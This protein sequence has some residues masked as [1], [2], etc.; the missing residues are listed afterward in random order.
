MENSQAIKFLLDRGA[1]VFVTLT[2]NN[3][4]VSLLVQGGLETPCRVEIFMSSN[5]KKNEL[6]VI[7]RKYVDVLYYEREDSNT[8]GSFVEKEEDVSE[9]QSTHK[10]KKS[11]KIKQSG[12]KSGS[13]RST[14]KAS[15]KGIHSFFY[16][17]TKNA[18]QKTDFKE[19]KKER[20]KYFN[21]LELSKVTH[22]KTINV[23]ENY[24]ACF[25]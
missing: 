17:K 19:R 6:I 12:Q 13:I 21:S 11:P 4:C 8:V 24:K 18:H 20:K 23:L 14:S 25:I 16:V 9:R 3:Y 1:R 2:S 22:N 10:I 7:F 5:V 15:H